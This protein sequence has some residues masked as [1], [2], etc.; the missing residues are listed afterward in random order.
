MLEDHRSPPALGFEC[1]AER[2]NTK[3]K[4]GSPWFYANR[5]LESDHIEKNTHFQ[6]E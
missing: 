5:R 3:G 4:K 6:H 1:A 2:G